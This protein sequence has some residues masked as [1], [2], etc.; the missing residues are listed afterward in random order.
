[1]PASPVANTNRVHGLLLLVRQATFCWLQP[2]LCEK[3]NISQPVPA[4]HA[5][6]RANSS[7]LVSANTSFLPCGRAGHWHV[8]WHEHD[9]QSS[10]TFSAGGPHQRISR[11]SAFV[12]DWPAG[13]RRLVCCLI[14]LT[15]TLSC[16][17]PNLIFNSQDQAE[18]VGRYVL[19]SQVDRP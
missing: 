3:V 14:K 13:R 17:C 12:G 19:K 15:Y 8:H 1:M 18:S 16:R 11:Y 6:G 9:E 7:W 4:A 2:S 5:A 10:A